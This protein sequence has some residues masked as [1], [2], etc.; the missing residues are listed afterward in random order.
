[1]ANNPK[2]AAASRNTELNA[3]GALANSGK[4][5]IYSGT[6]PADADTTLSG[7]TLLAELTMNA[8]AFASATAGVITANSVTS[9]SGADA[10]GTA[11]F[12]RLFASNGTTVIL[13]GSVG[14]ASA[15]LV[16]TTTEIVATVPVD[17]TALTI[18][19]PA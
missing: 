15:D 12:F 6:Q 4:L 7:N 2:V 17:V 3:L 9:D 16:L 11:T 5:R 18:T 8:T 1:M 19:L 10:T 13:D 14:T